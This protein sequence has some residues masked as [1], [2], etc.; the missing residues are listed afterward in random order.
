MA[1]ATCKGTGRDRDYGT[2]SI[3]PVCLGS[4]ALPCGSASGL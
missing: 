4:I 1:K 2:Q 3:A